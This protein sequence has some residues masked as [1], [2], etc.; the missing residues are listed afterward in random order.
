MNKFFSKYGPWAVIAG[1]S[2]GIGASVAEQLAKKGLN[3]VLIARSKDKLEKL[4]EDIRQKNKVEIKTIALDLC[5]DDVVEQIEAEV[6]DLDIGLFVYMAAWAY[7]GA[8]LAAEM[9]EYEYIV[10]LNIQTPLA[11]VY[12]FGRK[13]IAKR[14]GGIIL[15]S[16]S[17]GINGQPYNAL[18]ASTKAWDTAFAMGLWGE[19][20][21]YN[22][23]V[24]TS[25]IGTTETP[26]LHMVVPETY[27]KHMTGFQTA[28]EVAIETIEALGKQAQIITGK[29]NRRNWFLLRMLGPNRAVALVVDKM[30]K[31]FYEGNP[32]KQLG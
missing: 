24:L 22:V 9:K 14:R 13:M 10:K 29:A 2:Y 11:L 15:A 28:D 17:A 5:R 30:E 4:G 3:L 6:K 19:F 32:P 8:F 21:S 7:T 20:K 25:I 16:S 23:D 12:H 18:Y 27:F 31:E 26:G 1:A